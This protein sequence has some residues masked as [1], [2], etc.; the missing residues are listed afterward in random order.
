L[1]LWLSRLPASQNREKSFEFMVVEAVSIEPVSTL[2][3]L[4]TGKKT[5]NCG[6]PHS[7]RQSSPLR[8]AVSQWLSGKFPNI[9]NREFFGEIWDI[10]RAIQ[11]TRGRD[12]LWP[13]LTRFVSAELHPALPLS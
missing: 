7:Y 8:Y 13:F 5:G 2:D 1:F 9:Q 6:K 11:A 3:S 10:N 4:L 12:Q